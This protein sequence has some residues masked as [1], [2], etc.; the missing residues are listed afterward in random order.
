MCVGGR[1]WRWG[2]VGGKNKL[3][4]T[5]EYNN[6]FRFEVQKSFLI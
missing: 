5:D 3:F 1:V 4:C 6:I 2:E